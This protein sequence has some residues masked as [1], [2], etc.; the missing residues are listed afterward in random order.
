MPLSE[1]YS[2]Y[3]KLVGLLNFYIKTKNLYVVFTDRLMCIKWLPQGLI[4]LS[5][6]INVKRMDPSFSA[7]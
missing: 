5:S 6:R 4:F 3:E 2:K 1:R 7:H